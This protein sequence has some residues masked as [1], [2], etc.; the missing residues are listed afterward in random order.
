M[1]IAQMIRDRAA[2]RTSAVGLVEDAIAAAVAAGAASPFSTT[3]FDRARGQ[4]A[5]ADAMGPGAGPLAGIPLAHKDMFERAGARM[6]RGAHPSLAYVARHTAP[7]LE[8]LDRAGAVDLGRLQMSEFAMGPTGSNH[9][10]PCP[11]N[12]C[13]PGAIIGGSSSGSGVAVAMGIVPAALGS[14]TG[15]SIRIPAACNGVVGFKPTHGLVPLAHV[16]PLSWTQDCVG[17]LAASVDCA[18]RVLSVLTEGATRAQPRDPGHLRIGFDAGALLG[19]ISPAMTEALRLVR[20]RMATDGHADRDVDLAWLAH[21]DEPANVIAMAEAGTVHADQLRKDCDLYGTQVRNRL[22]QAAAISAQAYLR[23]CQLR[24]IAQERI[25]R[26]FASVDVIALPMM[27]DIPPQVAELSALEGAS[28]SRMISAVTRFSRPA[29]LMGLPAISVPV[30]WSDAG[31]LS[32]QL[33]GPPGSEDML[34]DL[35]TTVE[36]ARLPTLQTT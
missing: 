33:I 30:A 36:A 9:H 25:A 15:G 20:H 22:A 5:A 12:P 34:A 29:S 23:A 14:D 21:L 18:R 26:V 2:G 24:R 35:A 8:R 32:L 13:V 17:P 19:G 10:H 6:G 31:P 3:E 28:L 4:A 27:P 7:V 16:M 11:P 1:T